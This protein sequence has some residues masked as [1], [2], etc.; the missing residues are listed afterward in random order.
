MLIVDLDKEQKESP[1]GETSIA[2]GNFDGFHNGHREL[3]RRTIQEEHE[4]GHLSSVLLFKNHTSDYV[5]RGGGKRLNS[6]EDKIAKLDELGISCIYLATFDRAMMHMPHEEFVEEFLLRR[7]HTRHL[8]VGEDYSFGRGALGD[9]DYLL[10]RREELHYRVS[11]IPEVTCNG[12]RISST[13]IRQCIAAGGIELANCMLGYAYTIR[14][15]VVSGA[16]RGHDLGFPTANLALQFD[17]CLPTDGVYLVRAT[18]E[19]TGQQY[20]GMTNIG[21]NP[22]FTDDSTVKIETYLFDFSGDIY[23][24]VLRLEF[25]R[26]ERRD[27]KFDTKEELIRRMQEDERVLRSWVSVYET[28]GE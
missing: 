14:G 13:R 12:K 2:L 18:I 6:L 19:A 27:I 23:D 25:L 5:P 1:F 7:L 9:V 21:T 15:R 10:R 26:F 22:T 17:Y 28:L 8:V 3:I 4:F 16:S 11:V 20:F 24:Q